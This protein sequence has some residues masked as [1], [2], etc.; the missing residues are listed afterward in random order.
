M[1]PSGRGRGSPAPAFFLDLG[2]GPPSLAPSWPPEPLG[3]GRLKKKASTAAAGCG[4]D[5][6]RIASKEIPF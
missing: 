4:I 5:G 1:E 2:A 3:T 6:A